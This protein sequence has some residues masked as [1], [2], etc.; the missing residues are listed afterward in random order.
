MAAEPSSVQKN[1][2]WHSLLAYAWAFSA[3]GFQRLFSIPRTP[4]W[5]KF[6]MVTPHT[7]LCTWAVWSFNVF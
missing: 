5:S 1:S 4:E 7:S 6:R 3:V 2:C